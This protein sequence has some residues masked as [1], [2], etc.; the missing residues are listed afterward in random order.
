MAW[1]LS[2]STLDEGWK[3]GSP[4]VPYKLPRLL[5]H[6][7]RVPGL[8]RDSPSWIQLLTVQQ[9]ATKQGRD[10]EKTGAPFPAS[11]C[12]P[13]EYGQ[14]G[15]TLQ[16]RITPICLCLSYIN[17]SGVFQESTKAIFTRIW[18]V[19]TITVIRLWSPEISYK[20]NTNHTN[21]AADLYF[22]YD[23]SAVT[24]WGICW[25]NREQKPIKHVSNYNSYLNKYWSNL[26]KLY[27]N[28]VKC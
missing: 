25:G 19:E 21:D 13:L 27:E 23:W 5:P 2:L 6:K 20:N 17:G 16:I 9:L 11:A 15:S 7:G 8:S 26:L 14:C 1:R 4:L 12:P 18:E 28:I 3:T 10:R 24:L 22:N